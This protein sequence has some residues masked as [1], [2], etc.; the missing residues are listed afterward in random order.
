VRRTRRTILGGRFW[1]LVLKELRQ[2]RRDRRL[3]VSLIVPP[4]LQILL[5][6]FAL[7]PQVRNLQLA[8]VDESRTSESRELIS[9]LTENRTFQL[10]GSYPT[11]SALEQ[12]ISRGRL[13]IG[14]VIPRDFARRRARGQPVTVQ[15][16]VNAVNANTAQIAQGYVEGAVEWL[17]VRSAAAASPPVASVT[18]IPDAAAPAPVVMARP[19]G[20]PVAS[21]KA[22]PINR[23]SA[24]H[25]AE[26]RAAVTV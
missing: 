10:A 25:H 1:A 24:W 16:L 20:P 4:T 18:T 22:L 14:V 2:I 13:D 26:I 17:N 9:I 7:D 21:G 8:V 12:D 6:G 11:A 19:V 15:V 3:T 23:M 5:F